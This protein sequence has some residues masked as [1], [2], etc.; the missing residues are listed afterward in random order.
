MAFDGIRNWLGNVRDRD[1]TF[2]AVETELAAVEPSRAEPR[3]LP[4]TSARVVLEAVA[5]KLLGAWLANR[6]QTLVP[7]TLNFAALAEEQAGVLV[8]MMASAAQ[9]DGRIDEF[10]RER[11]REALDRVGA[12]AA[13]VAMLEQALDTPQ[14]L[15]LILSDAHGL[16]LGSHAYAAALLT[17]D[18]TEPVNAA[19]LAYAAARLRLP[20]DVVASLESRY[21]G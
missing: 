19:F 16:G 1:G 8:R 21:R 20:P 10:E 17:I 4:L 7:H 3:P 12:Q 6:H 11:I 5:T 15:A 9:A 13:Q 2:T 18:S 14:P